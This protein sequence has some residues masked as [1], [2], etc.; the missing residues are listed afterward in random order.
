MVSLF[1]QI[2]HVVWI[3]LP[4]N[5]RRIVEEQARTPPSST[6]VC[7]GSNSPVLLTSSITQKRLLTGVNKKKHF[8]YD[9]MIKFMYT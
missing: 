4:E 3:D 6:L 1:V 7:R 2:S 8:I 5:R 9:T